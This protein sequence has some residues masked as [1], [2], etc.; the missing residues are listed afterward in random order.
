NLL[1]TAYKSLLYLIIEA[2]LFALY[3]PLALLRSGPRI[4][5]GIVSFL[6]IPLWLIGSL[7]VL[8]CFWDFTFKGRGTPVPMDPPKELVVTGFYHYVRNPIYVGVLL[9]FLGHFLWFG[10]WSLLIYS[11]LAFIGVHLF[12]VLYE[13]PTLQRRFGAAYEDYLKKVPRWI[14]RFK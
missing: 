4:E 6:A 13:E 1:M 9:I 7:V 5:T 2:G 12:I 11:M 10:Y 8:W 14:P 3:I